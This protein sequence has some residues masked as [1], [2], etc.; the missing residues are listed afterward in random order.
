MLDRSAGEHKVR[1]YV[2]LLTR[3]WFC[4]SSTDVDCQNSSGHMSREEACIP[5]PLALVA[6]GHMSC[7]EALIPPTPFSRRHRRRGRQRGHEV[8]AAHAWRAH[9]RPA[10]AGASVRTYLAPAQFFTT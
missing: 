6:T 2:S 4:S 3:G 1:P 8:T 5:Q 9:S 10:S 7:E